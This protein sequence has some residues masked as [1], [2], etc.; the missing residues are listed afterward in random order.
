MRIVRS[1]VSSIYDCV[2]VGSGNVLAD[3]GL[4]DAIELD[5]KLG[6][7]VEIVRLLAKRRLTKTT[8]PSWLKISRSRV[9]AL[10]NYKLDGFSVMQLMTYCWHLDTV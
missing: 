3:L 4:P 10:R 2:E 9:S 5:V 6:I 7:A 8:A 1:V